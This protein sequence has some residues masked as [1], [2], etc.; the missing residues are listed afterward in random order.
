MAVLPFKQHRHIWR[1]D[2]DME[3]NYAKT[4]T[5]GNS[6]I[7]IVAPPPMTEEQK[8][9]ILDDYHAAGWKIIDELVERG[10]AV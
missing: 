7:H 4:Y 5:I 3:K 1:G 8:E 6:T 2:P 9:R 10:E